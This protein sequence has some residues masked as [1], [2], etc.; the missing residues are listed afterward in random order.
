[1]FNVTRFFGG[2]ESWGPYALLA[3][4]DRLLLLSGWT[5]RGADP[6][7]VPFALTVGSTPTRDFRPEI[8]NYEHRSGEAVWFKVSPLWYKNGAS[9][10]CAVQLAV[11]VQNRSQPGDAPYQYYV[12]AQVSDTS[13]TNENV[14]WVI[15]AGDH[16][17]YLMQTRLDYPGGFLIERTPQGQWL[18]QYAD[19]Q[20]REG[21]TTNMRLQFIGGSWSGG[22]YNQGLD[23]VLLQPDAEGDTRVLGR[24]SYLSLEF[25]EDN[26]GGM[27]NTPQGPLVRGYW[28]HI[29]GLEPV[30]PDLMRRY[31]P[32]GSFLE[33]VEGGSVKLY[34]R[35][36]INGTF[37]AVLW[38]IQ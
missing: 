31:F 24:V 35:Y 37:N 23:G 32:P 30:L 25:A 21:N 8:F 28:A 34:Q 9:Y 29:N 1:M 16:G 26:S 18:L 17:F 10:E 3:E 15:G 14:E 20:R 33:S 27:A 7:T 38:R 5:R 4:L 13:H 6:R 36:G 19:N 2:A 22:F 11:Y 12:T